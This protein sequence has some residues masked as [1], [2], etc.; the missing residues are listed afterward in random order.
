MFIATA[1]SAVV[2]VVI[3]AIATATTAVDNK[4]MNAAHLTCHFIVSAFFLLHFHCLSSFFV[5]CAM[6]KKGTDGRAFGRCVCDCVF[7]AR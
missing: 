5:L 1:S 6:A 4:K 2:V 7:Q 3:V